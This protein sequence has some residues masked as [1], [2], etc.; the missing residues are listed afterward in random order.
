MQGAGAPSRRP[1]RRSGPGTCRAL[2]AFGQHR[3]DSRTCPRANINT[4]KTCARTH[5]SLACLVRRSRSVMSP[6]RLLLQLPSSARS[7]RSADKSS[8]RTG[9]AKQTLH[10]P[11]SARTYVPHCTVGIRRT[12]TKYIHTAGRAVN[13]LH[14][15][16][17]TQFPGTPPIL[18]CRHARCTDKLPLTSLYSSG[19][20]FRLLCSRYACLLHRGWLT[21]CTSFVTVASSFQHMTLVVSPTFWSLLVL[22]SSLLSFS[23]ASLQ[24]AS[25]PPFS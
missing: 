7:I 5:S 21:C 18:A 4:R 10:A 12:C 8:T 9:C 13:C 11:V 15:L 25:A 22:T 19:D 20:V 1:F 3:S 24:P 14:G 2:V 17:A 6:P 23:R 16:R